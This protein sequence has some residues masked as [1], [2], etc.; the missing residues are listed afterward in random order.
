MNCLICQKPLDDF[1]PLC[2]EHAPAWGQ[3]LHIGNTTIIAGE[4]GL[5]D[6]LLI[7]L[8]GRKLVRW[9]LGTDVWLLWAFPKG[10]GKFSVLKHR[11]K[12]YLTKFF[13][14]ENW[15][16][17]EKLRDEFVACG[18]KRASVKYHIKGMLTEKVKKIAHDLVNIAY[19]C[20]KDSGESYRYKY[21]LDLIEKLELMFP[22]P[23][24]NWIPLDGKFR[25]SEI[26]T[27]IDAMIRPSRHDGRPRMIEE[28]KI[29]S[30]PYYY[31]EDR[32]PNLEDM[33]NFVQE[34]IDKASRTNCQE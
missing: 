17:A 23:I 11:L 24:V 26:Y 18:G 33:S 12:Y 28:C 21:G 29:N 31:S 10:R 15:V 25:M 14:S 27:I 16:T 2:N 32:E 13:V 30:I 3:S 4:L 19:Y 6:A 8:M 5:L 1:T 34:T 20:P 7:K 22:Y 9:W